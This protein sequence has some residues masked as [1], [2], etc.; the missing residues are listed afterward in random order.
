MPAKKTILVFIAFLLCA[1]SCQADINFREDFSISSYVALT[2]NYVHRGLSYTGDAITPQSS[3]SISHKSG[4]F[5]NTWI[6]R[7][8]ISGLFGDE[9]RR[10]TEFEFN[11]GYHWQANSLWSATFSHA[12]LEYNRVHQPVN[13]DYR[14]LRL[15]IHYTDQF[16]FFAA[17]TDSVWGTGH[18]LTSLSFTTRHVAPYE[19]LLE[20]EV[21]WLDFASEPR[22]DFLFSRISLGKALSQ[23]WVATLDYSYSHSRANRVFDSDRTG[24]QFSL[25]LSY[26]F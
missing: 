12:W 5:L 25:S 6:A 23:H 14:E 20:A 15:N 7:D 21:G 2:T 19:T 16:S 17:H 13:H 10:D 26:H 22:T 8:D 1:G 11:L 24:N 9:E 3:L 4:A 18:D